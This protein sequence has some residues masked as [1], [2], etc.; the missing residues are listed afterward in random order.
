MVSVRISRFLEDGSLKYG[1][2]SVGKRF[3]LGV[4][5]QAGR[6]IHSGDRGSG[7]PESNGGGSGSGKVQ[8]QLSRPVRS[9]SS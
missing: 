4:G 2:G 1:N 3:R 9:D 5:S 6:R 7:C 8:R